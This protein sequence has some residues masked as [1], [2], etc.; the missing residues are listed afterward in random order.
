MKREVSIAF[1]K[2]LTIK[3]E[4]SMSDTKAKPI[5]VAG[6]FKKKSPADKVA[7]ATGIHAGI[8]SDPTDYPTPPVDEATFKSTIDSLSAKITPALDGS[9]KAIADRKHEEDVLSNMVR[10]LGQYVELACK[11]DMTTFLKSGFQPK[12]TVP[13]VKQ[14][15][16]QSIRTI[17][18]GKK[19]GTM[20]IAPGN[21]GADAYEVRL[22]PVVNGTPGTPTTQLVTKTRPAATITG[23]TPGTTYSIQVRSF[24]DATGFSD[25]G[26]PVIRICT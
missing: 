19:T 6:G 18:P 11:D 23:L 3:K 7:Y 15:V 26:D 9:K 17:K 10:Q 21:V 14:M 20:Y 22:T 8:F 13:A 25:W 4:N 5:K 24:A 12:S 1:P 16:S 2:P